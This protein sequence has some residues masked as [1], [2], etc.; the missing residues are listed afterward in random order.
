M[1]PSHH[2]IAV[3]KPRT[4][5]LCRGVRPAHVCSI[6]PLSPVALA[7]RAFADVEKSR[8]RNHVLV[9]GQFDLGAANLTAAVDAA[10]KRQAAAE[11]AGAAEVFDPL[12]LR[13]WRALGRQEVQLTYDRQR[14]LAMLRANDGEPRRRAGQ[15]WS[16]AAGSDSWA[17]E[18]GPEGAATDIMQQRQWQQAHGRRHEAH[19]QQPGGRQHSPPWAWRQ[20]KALRERHALAVNHFVA[21]RTQFA[22]ALWLS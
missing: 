21:M 1:Q 11:A 22:D 8:V 14:C 6:D 15:T 12:Q 7:V 18:T 9:A 17:G 13:L 5:A 16:T 4:L 19:R 10:A 3:V 20:L 2:G